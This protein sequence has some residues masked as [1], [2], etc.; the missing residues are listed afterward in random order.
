[1]PERTAPNQT[2]SEQTLLS[3][4]SSRI[5]DH[6]KYDHRTKVCAAPTFCG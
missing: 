2:L 6:V 5:V 4:F 1:M 3:D